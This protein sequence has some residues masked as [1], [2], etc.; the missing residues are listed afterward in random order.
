LKAAYPYGEPLGS[1]VVPGNERAIVVQ[2]AT[3]TVVDLTTLDLAGVHVRRP[4]LLNR[5][6][7]QLLVG[8][9][10]AGLLAFGRSEN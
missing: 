6:L 1:T 2:G 4:D 10:R 9:N 7:D 8:D 5:Q 3:L